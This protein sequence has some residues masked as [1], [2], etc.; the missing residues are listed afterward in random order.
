MN[1]LTNTTL[2]ILSISI[3]ATITV[4]C[5]PFP[6]EEPTPRLPTS[7][8]AGQ[9][10]TAPT[11]HVRYPFKLRQADLLFRAIPPL[12]FGQHRLQLENM[13]PPKALSWK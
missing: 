2:I 8:T 5:T 13:H 4:G 1:S 9:G 10:N 12:L 7:A 3:L 6:T 11:N